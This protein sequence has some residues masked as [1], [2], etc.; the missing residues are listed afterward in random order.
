MLRCPVREPVTTGYRSVLA[1]PDKFKGSATA[2]DIAGAIAAACAGLGVAAR[3]T[4]LADGGEGTLE[5]FGGA[6]RQTDVLGPLGKPVRAPWRFAGDDAVVEMARASGLV[7]AGGANRNRP[8]D[9]STRGTGQLIAAAVNAGARRILVGVGGSATTD[10]GWN[11]VRV[12]H[13]HPPTGHFL[14]GVELSVACDVTTRFT[15]AARVFAP[16]KGATAEQVAHL[17]E[18][19]HRLRETY[20]R[21]FGVDVNDIPGSGAAGGLAGGL[22]ALGAELRPGF[23]LVAERLGLD[24]ALDEV[25]L[26]ITGEGRLDEQSFTGK[27]VG[28]VLARASARGIPTLAIVGSSAL[29]HPPPGLAVVSLEERYGGRAWTDTLGCV[30]DA[31]AGFVGA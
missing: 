20:R 27:V 6:N 25:D 9:A 22:A 15:D 24:A 30:S 11:A 26:V 29:P 14:D 31:V 5:A 4:P 10:G 12:L 21:E 28:G 3:T 7:L 8:L 18:R 13:E 17:T 19:L 1:A 2:A 16:Q 23:D